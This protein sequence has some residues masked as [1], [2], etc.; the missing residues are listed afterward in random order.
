VPRDG[1]RVPPGVS[2]VGEHGVESVS[3]DP[4]CG[5]WPGL[6]G[7]APGGVVFG[8]SLA[9][10][11]A[12]TRSELGLPVDLPLIATG[13]QA[14]WWHPGILAKY[15]AVDHVAKRLGWATANLIVDQHDAEFGKFE[16]AVRHADGL[17]T[18]RELRLP[19]SASG[20]VMG[21]QPAIVKV[22]EIRLADDDHATVLRTMRKAM[23]AHTD[24]PNVAL[25][26]ARAMTDV[27]RDHAGVA[28]MPVLTA[29]D[30]MSTGFVKELV[31]A[32]TA[33]PTRCAV[34][35]NAAVKA[36]PEARLEPL[37]VRDDYIEVPLWRID[38]EGRRKRAYDSDAEAWLAVD[39][40]VRPDLMPRAL[41][42]TAIMRLAVCDLFVHGVGGGVYDHAMEHWLRDWLG[43]VVS[44]MATVTATVRQPF[45][46]S[47]DDPGEL[48]KA[49][50]AARRLW[51]DPDS[52]G[53]GESPS[54]FKKSL[55][56]AI[57]AQDRNSASRRQAFMAMHHALQ[58]SR[59]ARAN[60][61]SKSQRRADQARINAA[62]RKITQRRDWAWPLYPRA[63][64]EALQQVIAD[65]CGA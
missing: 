21:R 3:I 57:N 44:P 64:I 23:L 22:E 14:L 39:A 17:L 7:S 28:P 24:A 42:M 52:I 61:I 51:H 2:K 5:R 19:A 20:R 59:T 29:T 9:E 18:V 26:M 27:M 31:L 15:I 30:L 10:W 1:V 50:S 46:E 62:N 55:V 49:M 63:S 33:D 36:V 40:A 60:D 48:V 45:S 37:L 13:H 34:A 41:L 43:V 65:Q 16:V 54:E 53:N 35:Y 47:N 32:M 56:I 8:R 12:L 58:V 38:G 6:I 25:Q 11:R 4:P